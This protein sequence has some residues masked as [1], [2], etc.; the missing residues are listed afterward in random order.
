MI[1]LIEG[2][3][4]KTTNKTFKIAKQL[5]DL[6]CNICNFF[7]S[8]FSQYDSDANKESHTKIKV[9]IQSTQEKNPATM[10]AAQEDTTN[11]FNQQSNAHYLLQDKDIYYIL[12]YKNLKVSIAPFLVQDLIKANLY[13]VTNDQDN[14]PETHKDVKTLDESKDQEEMPANESSSV[15]DINK[16]ENT[17]TTSD[18]KNDVQQI[19]HNTKQFREALIS[20]IELLFH[21]LLRKDVEVEDNPPLESKH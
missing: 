1:S 19:L 21:N 17:P 13:F 12:E 7:F 9:K 14:T 20:A 11:I 5:S 8:F 15:L 18:D 2:I 4:Y 10:Q 3:F 6:S 16:G